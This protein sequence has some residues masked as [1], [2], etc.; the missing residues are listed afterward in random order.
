MNFARSSIY[1]SSV[2]MVFCLCGISDSFA[3]STNTSSELISTSSVY[4]KISNVISNTDFT[5][6][7]K[8]TVKLENG[9]KESYEIFNPDGERIGLVSMWSSNNYIKQLEIATSHNND[10]DT[11]GIAA[12]VVAA[13]AKAVMDPNE[14]DVNLFTKMLEEATQK[15]DST[16]I[17]PS[18]QKVTVSWITVVKG[19]PGLTF[20]TLNVYYNQNIPV[21]SQ[22]NPQNSPSSLATSQVEKSPLVNQQAIAKKDNSEIN[23]ASVAVGIFIIFGIPAII[24]GLI[25]W[26]IKKN[27]ARKQKIRESEWKG[28]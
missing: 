9:V 8:S 22:N 7:E 12:I 16:R 18:G 1:I 15:T 19:T 10:L 20:L 24:I 3:E 17:L 13:L 28:V 5:L 2:L 6:G 14:Y 26:K 27:K 25:I 23:P 4:Q 21:Q 11:A